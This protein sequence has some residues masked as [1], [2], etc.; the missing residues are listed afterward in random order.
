MKTIIVASKNPVKIRSIQQAF[1]EVFN[2]QFLIEGVST[3]SGVSDQPIG[4]TETY[5]GAVNRIEAIKKHHP[6]AH[7]WA[8]IEG[9]IE[10]KG[11]QF[12]CMAWI[13]IHSMDG[14]GE[15]RVASFPL[16]S[17]VCE[18]LHQGMELGDATARYFNEPNSKQRMGVVGILTNGHIDRTSYYVHAAKL[19]LIPLVNKHLYS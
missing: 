4:D 14:A 8:S 1:E 11:N 17:T 7:F 5:Q 16:P 10:L 15:S 12:Y 6:N 3:E 19:A 2:D 18:L 9:G 13:I